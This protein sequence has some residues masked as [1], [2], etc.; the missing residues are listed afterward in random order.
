MVG[1]VKIQISW[2]KPSINSSM[3][4][5]SGACTKVFIGSRLYSQSTA[6]RKY[7]NLILRTKK[8]AA[9]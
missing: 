6:T 3:V 5:A 2:V 1:V 8:F 7:E 9:F 4:T